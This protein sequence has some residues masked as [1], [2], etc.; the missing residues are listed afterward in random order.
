MD[1]SG[2]GVRYFLE[3]TKEVC[4]MN[5]TRRGDEVLV[6]DGGGTKFAIAHM[7]V[8]DDGVF[9][10]VRK[11]C[12]LLQDAMAAGVRSFHEL[13]EKCAAPK[14][15][16]PLTRARKVAVAAAGN[17]TGETVELDRYPF[18]MDVGEARSRFN[19]TSLVVLNDMEGQECYSQLPPSE[20][21]VRT[22]N[23]V[24]EDDID[25][26]GGTL[27]L[28]VGTGLGVSGRT[29]WGS[30]IRSEGGNIS[31]TGCV[32]R[33]LRRV[34]RRIAWRVP[35]QERRL[36]TVISGSGE[37][38]VHNC[39]RPWYFFRRA[40]S[41]Q[42]PEL[43][44]RYPETVKTWSCY[45]G[46]AVRDLAVAFWTTKAVFL[47]G[48]VLQRNPEL[49]DPEGENRFRDGLLF[50][51]KWREEMG[52]IPIYQVTDEDAVF[53]ALAWAALHHEKRKE[54]STDAS[55]VLSN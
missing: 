18:P 15:G 27:F 8:Q 29:G 26:T 17:V 5:R 1:A 7:E 20:R 24:P 31:L 38:L 25:Q 43:L 16:V 30:Q 37:A 3:V 52:R 19:W 11:A 32:P 40:T 45:L 34:H 23:F 10:P 51:R 36:E 42:M 54:Y 14:L 2:I 50:M 48:G 41:V 28:A 47:L 46:L 49:I 9:R 6:I 44:E 22:I 4:T 21:V 13:L 53:K 39:S 35:P 55:E 12:V 33:D